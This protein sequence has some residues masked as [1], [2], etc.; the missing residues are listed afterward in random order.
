MAFLPGLCRHLLGEE[1]QMPSVATWWCGQEEPRRYVLEHLDELVIK[2]AFRRFG[3]RPEFPATMDAAARADLA[4]R[5]EAQP[6]RFVA[7][8]HVALS[9]VPVRTDKGLVPRHLVLRV[10][11]AWDGESY[12]VMP[13]GLDARL[14]RSRRSVVSMQLG[15]GSKDTWVLED[16]ARRTIRR[17]PSIRL[18]IHEFGASPLQSAQP[19][20]RQSLLA[21]PLRRTRRS[22]RAPGARAAA[23]R[24][25]AKRIS[26]APLR[27]KPPSGCWPGC[28]TCRPR[29]PSPRSASSAGTCSGC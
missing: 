11:A 7:Q 5:I 15:G 28:I 21:G 19:R 16:P 25:P 8:E 9:T 10:F 20:G 24:S 14:H 13:G 2:P 23:R 29:F 1:L 26:A 27:S 6:E 17:A 4:R 18:R 3:Q 12:T 22:R